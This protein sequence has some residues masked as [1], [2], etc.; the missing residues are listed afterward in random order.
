MTDEAH[1]LLHRPRRTHWAPGPL[2]ATPRDGGVN[3]AV[4]SEHATRSSCACSTRTARA[5]CAA[6]SCRPQP[7]GV[8]HGFLPGAGRAG[9]RPARA[10]PLGA[11]AGPPL[12]PAQA[13]ARPLG[14]RDRRPLRLATRSTTAT[15]LGTPTAPTLVRRPRQR[16]A[17]AQ[18]ARGGAARPGAT[19]APMRR[20]M[21]ASTVLYEAARARAHRAHPACPSR[22]AAPTPA[23][24][25][26][27]RAPQAAR[28]DRAR[29]AAGARHLD[30]PHLVRPGLRQL[31]GLQH[32]RLLLPGAR[33]TPRAAGPT[34]RGDEFRPWSRRCTRR[35][36]RCC[37]TWSS[38]TPPRATSGPDAVAARPRQR[39]GTAWRTTT[40]AATRT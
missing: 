2:G 28:R 27:D 32:P 9:L 14:A 7:T 38:T 16:A 1:R 33:A 15:T 40:A 23:R 3:F 34:A 24:P 20:A 4:F 22:C 8:W 30:E 19:D 21:R 39:A 10:R 35:A 18:G 26:G 13:A 12:Q 29:A 25:P 37:S 5:S 31:L 6:T 11:G 36:S 17:G